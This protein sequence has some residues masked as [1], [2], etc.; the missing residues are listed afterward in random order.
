MTIPCAGK[1]EGQPELSY[2]A[3]GNTDGMV[4]VFEN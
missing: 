3:G 4:S 1:N 2:A